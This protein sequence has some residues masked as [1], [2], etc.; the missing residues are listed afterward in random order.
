M[1]VAVNSL[2]ELASCHGVLGR[3]GA[4]QVR[5]QRYCLGGRGTAGARTVK[6]RRRRRLSVDWC[7][8]V[9]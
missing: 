7:Q 8:P 4:G 2:Y 9:R 5:G 3:G 1:L 6:G